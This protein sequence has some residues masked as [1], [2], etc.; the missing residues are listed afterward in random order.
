MFDVFKRER[1]ALAVIQPFLGG[2]V[3]VLRVNW[4]R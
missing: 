2:L 4:T 1:A 3:P